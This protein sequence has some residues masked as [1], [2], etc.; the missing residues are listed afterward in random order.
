VAVSGAGPTIL[1]IAPEQAAAAVATA[2]EAA[3]RRLGIEAHAHAARVDHEGARI[4]T[5]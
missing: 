2:F 1:A 5:A 4:A 3:Y